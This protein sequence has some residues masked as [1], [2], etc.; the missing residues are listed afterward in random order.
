MAIK[1]GTDIRKKLL[2]GVNKL[3]DAVQ[4]TL[5]PRGRNVALEKAFGPPLVTKDGVSVAKEI[6]LHDPWENMGARLVREV[7]SKTSD[8]AGDGTTTAT[9]LA[10]NLYVN[11]M[12]LLEAG[13][14]PVNL[15]RGMDKALAMIVGEV[16]SIST[17]IR[18][19]AAIESVATVSANGDSDIGKVIAEAVAKVGKDGIVH[20]EEGKSTKTTLESTDGMRIERGWISPL[21]M[22]NP[23]T[24]SST[25]QDAFVFVTDMNVSAIRPFVPALEQ[26]V[27]EGRPILWIAPDFDGEAL[28]A[29]CQNFGQKSLISM[30]VKAPGFGANQVEILKDIATITGATFVS[31]ELG[32][33]H[34]DVTFESFGKAR[35]VTV[36]DK[37]TTIID[38]AGTEEAVEARIEELRGQIARA[39]SEF[40][41]EKIQ[42]RLGKLL[43][44]ICSIKVGAHS[45]LALKEIKGR[46]EDALYATKAAIDSGIV[47]GGGTTL[48]RAASRVEEILED[49]LQT[50]EEAGPDLPVNEEEIAG[51]RL[52]LR[53]CEEPF[54]AIVENGGHRADRY[55][56]RVKEHAEEEMGLDGR[57]MEFVNLRDVGVF[58]PT[59]VVVATITNAV[60][61]TGMML[62]T[63]A[64]IYKPSKENHPEP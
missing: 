28:A 13:L 29:L 19:A 22:M 25:L 59:K 48:I 38:G 54:R 35:T 51:F 16:E 5:G 61:V 3:A 1:H 26:I 45:E 31:K 62:T 24:Y 20:I 21:F 27:K 7:S 52:V 14:A 8:D 32:M 43:G 57:T 58:D 36:T 10:R 42:E 12:R 63:E 40:D 33:T 6:E 9:V 50:T 34:R 41:R 60:S 30:L 46:M 53:A 55:I 37:H 11:G 23:E 17:P 2:I 15:K 56:D 64:A 47:P 4:V 44:G 39:G 49:F 18:D